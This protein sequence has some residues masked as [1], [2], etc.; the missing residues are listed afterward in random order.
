MLKYVL[1]N[2]IQSWLLFM[3]SSRYSKADDEI[4]IGVSVGVVA[5]T[6]EELLGVEE[7]GEDD[8]N[9]GL[10]CCARS[11]LSLLSTLAVEPGP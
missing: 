4:L 10:E 9:M 3:I 11:K 1:F 2:K 7:T 5:I 8:D 6:T